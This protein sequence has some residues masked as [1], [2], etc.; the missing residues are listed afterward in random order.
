MA[1]QPLQKI[2]TAITGAT[3]AITAA[4]LLILSYLPSDDITEI[5]TQVADTVGILLVI[6]LAS[7]ATYLLLDE[8]RKELE[9]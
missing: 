9:D 8:V 2:L 6:A 1:F 4:Y 3:L 7:V 5:S